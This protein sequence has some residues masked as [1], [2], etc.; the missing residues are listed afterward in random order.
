VPPRFES[1]PIL[2]RRAFTATLH[3]TVLLD[4]RSQLGHGAHLFAVI[5]ASVVAR[6]VANEEVLEAVGPA[7]LGSLYLAVAVLSGALLAGF[8]WLSRKH[9]ARRV[10][11]WTHVAAAVLLAAASAVPATLRPGALVKYVLVEV[12][13]AALL[14]GFG[15][16]LGARFA[17]REARKIAP[18]V[19]VGGI[20]GGLAAG[21]VLSLGPKV[22]ASRWLFLIAAAVVLAP[23]TWL[24]RLDAAEVPPGAMGGPRKRPVVR[25]LAPYGRALAMTAFIAVIT[26]TLV[27]YVFRY[28]ARHYYRADELTAFFGNVVLVTGLV[29]AVFQLTLL[30][31]LLDRF[32]VFATAAVM[33]AVIALTGAVLG[34]VPAVATLF[35]FKLAD[36]GANMTVQQST[37]SLLLAP[38][39]TTARS[40][41]QSRVDGVA[42]RVGLALV[43][44][45]LVAFPWTPA[46]LLPAT[47]GLC[48]LWLG[49]LAFTRSRYIRLLT[50]M[51]REGDVVDSTLRPTDGATV[52]LLESELERA[53]PSR[54]A[55][56]LDLLAD[57]GRKASPHTL[58]R[59]AGH[60]GAAPGALLALDHL[61]KLRDVGALSAFVA[62]PRPEV[63]VRAL[64]EVATLDLGVAEKLCRQ[65]L[66]E[67]TS[68]TAVRACA[69]G[70]LGNADPRALDM[71]VTL[72][73]DRDP[74]TREAVVVG[75]S[76]TPAGGPAAL[77]DLVTRLAA[78]PDDRVAARALEALPRHA[79]A[80]SIEV[81][82][83]S[84]GRRAVRGAAMRALAGF[85]P[86]A[87]ERVSQELAARLHETRTAAAL[88]WVLGR[89]GSGAAVGALLETLWSEH[90]ELRLA[91]AIA[92]NSLK[93]RRPATVIPLAAVAARF[94]PE[95][96]W[97]AR[98][99]DASH[100][101][102]AGSG[103][104]RLLTHLAKQRAQASLECLFRLLA[105]RYPEEAL[106]GT[107]L[108]VSSG[109]RRRRQLA[110]ELLDTLI[111]PELRSALAA[112]V[113]DGASRRRVGDP[114]TVLVELARTGD[115]FL[116]ALSR[117]VLAERGVPAPARRAV[118]M[119][120]EMGDGRVQD[121]LELQAVSV[122][123]QSSAEDLAEL[124][125]L[126]VDRPVKRGEVIFCEGDAGDALYLVRSGKIVL[127][128]EK[129][130]VDEVGPGEAFGIVAVLDQQPRELTAT[131]AAD[132]VLR[133]L[134]A[135]DLLQLLSERPLFMHSV[136]R[137]L[138]QAIRGQLERAALGKRTDVA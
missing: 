63:A 25:S 76:V 127:T 89:L 109:D 70:L 111:D 108:A 31:R 49:A 107:L 22:V 46:R 137:A 38:L 48:V 81:A 114:T 117:R 55:V 2:S 102:L 104:G 58:A 88:A 125:S 68:A 69:A 96:A 126:L 14:L 95:I 8:G 118:A 64:V 54:A 35:V 39:S 33:P 5:A 1:R 23:I 34:A 65:V 15:R 112:A 7:S 100:L 53:S 93:R 73:H 132:G 41:W 16:L 82:L 24:V 51:L 66:V 86:L 122:F 133:V 50:D 29:A 84:V 128:R 75:T 110:L 87:A 61:A 17:P 79:T 40:V 9:E 78:D 59:I 103:A 99:R 44:I 90:A 72:S 47:L 80:E 32:G 121:V 62:D 130:V 18:R 3:G 60:G 11:L 71:A 42:R 56:I 124:A 116:A 91:G 115:P 45:F 4:W 67:A 52:R 57:A 43:G 21:L 20:A 135:D 12:I 106:R 113:S 13:A 36:S 134:A 101:A 129:A 26:T 83:A 74:T 77:S 98:M 19:G 37:S 120:V 136:F 119:E 92:L 123:G 10:A 138:T 131:I 85:G 105:L 30:D 6:N 94:E 97:Y 27:D 28:S